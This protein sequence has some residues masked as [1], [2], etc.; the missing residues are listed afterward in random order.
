[1]KTGNGACRFVEAQCSKAEEEKM[2]TGD[3]FYEAGEEEVDVYMSN[4]CNHDAII[5]EGIN[6]HG[7][8]NVA[9][10]LDDTLFHVARDTGVPMLNAAI[11]GGEEFGPGVYKSPEIVSEVARHMAAV[12]LEDFEKAVCKTGNGHGCS[13]PD[14]YQ[15]FKDLQ[16]FYENAAQKGKGVIKATLC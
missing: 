15:E 2:E 16:S 13:I 14:M 5:G 6:W 7:M 10:H 11:Y 8:K 1:M 12:T 3:I 9:C 4:P